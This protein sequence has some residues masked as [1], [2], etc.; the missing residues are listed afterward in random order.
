MLLI[1]H[2]PHIQLVEFFYFYHILS[3]TL[4]PFSSLFQKAQAEYEAYVKL[5]AK[6]ES[7]WEEA[8]EKSDFEMFRP[9]PIC[10]KFLF[11]FNNFF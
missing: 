3:D 6:A 2:K 8:R 5:E 10:N 1:S 7:V 4:Q 9:S 11:K